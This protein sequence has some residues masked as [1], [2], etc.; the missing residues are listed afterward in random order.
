MI[1]SDGFFLMQIPPWLNLQAHKVSPL[2]PHC[3]LDLQK[4]DS[5]IQ[6]IN[7][8]SSIIYP[9]S[10]NHK[11]ISYQ[12]NLMLFFICFLYFTFFF[13][14]IPIFVDFFS[15]IFYT[16]F[17]WFVSSKIIKVVCLRNWSWPPTKCMH[18]YVILFLQC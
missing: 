9:T 6:I 17:N 16:L 5:N 7:F 18:C 1:Y 4:W 10:K 11:L 2:T 8:G 15:N 13:L 12:N 3:E 14:F